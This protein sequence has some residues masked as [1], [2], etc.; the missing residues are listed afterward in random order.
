M[1]AK[2]LVGERL[3]GARTAQGLSLRDLAGMVGVSAQALS[4][5]ERGDVMPGS[6]MLISLAR[7]LRV[8]IEFFFRPVTIALADLEFR[9]KN[10]LQAK[11][12]RSIIGRIHDW[13]ER[14]E[15]I[16]SLFPHRIE[17][18]FLASD[19]QRNVS[20]ADEVEAIAMELRNAWNL[21]LAPIENMTALLEEHGVR[22][23][24]IGDTTDSFDACAFRANGRCGIVA[25][26]ELPGDRLRFNLAHELGYLI[27]NTLEE[28]D[29]RTREKPTMRFA[30]AFLVPQDVAIRELGQKRHHL[31]I[32]ELY[33]LKRKYGLSM[34]AWIYRAK[35]LDIITPSTAQHLFMAFRKRGWLT[36][37]PGE[38]YPTE[39]EP[40][41]MRQLVLRAHAESL[42][43]ESKAAEL[44]G[45]NLNQFRQESLGQHV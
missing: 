22:V 30:A 35:D 34:S 10:A 41:M 25:Q 12:Q 38:P 32:D 11:E 15:Q 24:L 43:S 4:N 3:K 40:S 21:G 16:E 6:A 18:T 1:S 37:E 26:A 44:L 9:K 27:I 5:Y 14:Y 8:K 39:S 33:L 42:I 28:G 17:D 13:L 7:A 2:Q 36:R 45:L 23:Y 29:K 19:N 31:D 20:S